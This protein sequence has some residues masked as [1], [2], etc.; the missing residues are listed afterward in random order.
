[1]VT[2][3]SDKSGS[4]SLVELVTS[5]GSSG[6]VVLGIVKVFVLSGPSGVSLPTTLKITCTP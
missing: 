1:M 4:M 3:T 6:I 5:T 2:D